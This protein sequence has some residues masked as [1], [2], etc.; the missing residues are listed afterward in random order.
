MTLCTPLSPERLK[1]RYHD[2]VS[3]KRQADRSV[4]RRITF[5]VLVVGSIASI[6]LA[7]GPEWMVRIGVGVALVM[8]FV[9]VALSWRELERVHAAHRIEL[10][11]LYSASMEQA[12]RHHQESLAM[13]ERF[14]ARAEQ[15]KETINR[16]TSEL[17]A[18]RSELS[19]MR[20]NGAWLRGEIA[21]RQSRI[22]ALESRISELETAR[23]DARDNLI[24]LPR[25]GADVSQE[26][27]PTAEELWSDGNHPTVVDLRMLAFPEVFE[28][29]K[30]A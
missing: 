21:E 28:V 9:S 18:A 6:A 1:F 2:P 27:L 19:T 16:V 8:A 29:R 13:V 15:L 20:G 25:Y 26:D 17:A 12:N 7:F 14:D 22:F 24:Q 23:E 30:Q 4:E 11:A 5:A 10:K 3:G